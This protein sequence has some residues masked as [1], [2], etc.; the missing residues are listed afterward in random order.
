[1][2]VLISTVC[3]SAGTDHRGNL[4]KHADEKR[5]RV[6]EIGEFQYKLTQFNINRHRAS[7]LNQ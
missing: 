5:H 6:Q 3:K 4:V 7:E 2:K 1:M